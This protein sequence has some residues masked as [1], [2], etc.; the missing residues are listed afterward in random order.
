[1][2]LLARIPTRE[3]QDMNLP[4][5]I[6]TCSPL[7]MNLPAHGT[8]SPDPSLTSQHDN[9]RKKEF[10]VE[11][12]RLVLPRCRQEKI[13]LKTAWRDTIVARCQAASRPTNL[14]SIAQRIPSYR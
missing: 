11:P 3:Y 1:M 10:L 13:L 9:R 7:P 12:Y 14:G 5:H 4:T 2:N 6:I 8:I